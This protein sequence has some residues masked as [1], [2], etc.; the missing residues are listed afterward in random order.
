MKLGSK[1][2]LKDINVSN[3]K[4]SSLDISEAGTIEKIAVGLQTDATGRNQQQIKVTMTQQQKD[5]FDSKG[6]IF[7][8]NIIADNSDK[9]K[10]NSNVKV[11]IKQ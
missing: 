8:E 11:I 6:I 9:N 7:T 4:L 5:Y 2:G 1:N 10:P 3:S